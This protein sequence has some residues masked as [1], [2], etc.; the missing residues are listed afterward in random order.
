MQAV[1]PCVTMQKLQNHDGSGLVTIPKPFLDRDGLVDDGE[2]QAGQTIVVDRLGDG[3]YLVR[4]PTDGE[5]PNVE[6]CKVVERM[7]AMKAQAMLSE[8]ALSQRAD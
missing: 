1:A 4:T 8:N 3:C 7:A 6:E 5:L 2:P